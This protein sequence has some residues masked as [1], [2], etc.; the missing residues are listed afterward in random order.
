[1]CDCF[2]VWSVT[3]DKVKRKARKEH[4]CG[5]CNSKIKR[6][7][8]YWYMHGIQAEDGIH[9]PWSFKLCL[10][11]KK[12]WD[13]LRAIHNE[14][15]VDTCICYSELRQQVEEGVEEGYINYKSRLAWRW[16]NIPIPQPMRF[17]TA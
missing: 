7:Q 5:E 6:G 10:Q 2:G 12:D 8:K 15:R 14:A 16:R 17:A 9:E 1:M 3:D 13:Q 11:C 4:Y